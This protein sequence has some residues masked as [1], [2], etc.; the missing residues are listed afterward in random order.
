MI[1]FSIIIP[2]KNEEINIAHCLD[3]INAIKYDHNRFEVLVVDNGSID[4]TVDVANE[5]GAKVF[6]QP[7]LTISGLRNFGARQARGKVL[8]FL[9]ADC[10]VSENWLSAA[11]LYSDQRDVV[12]FGSPAVLPED[13]TWVQRAWFF[14]RCKKSQVEEVDWHES[15]NFFV[16]RESF[17]SVNG[18]DENL[19][20]CED[21]DLSLRLKKLGRLVA[22]D[23]IRA[24]H[25]REPATVRD[26]FNKE[27]WRSSSNRE[28]LV[29]GNFKLRELPSLILPLVH[30]LLAFLLVSL[31]LFEICDGSDINIPYFFLLLVWQLPLLF[32]A[33]WKTRRQFSFVTGLQLY[34]LLN[35][36]FF[37]RGFACMR[38]S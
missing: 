20:T 7:D 15:A 21:Y 16:R 24:M 3:S 27:R 17:E 23:R 18:F 10:T 4:L 22:D 33:F 12:A 19:V 34:A 36:Y 6:V 5:K 31:V 1:D 28:R 9:D 2:A 30:C 38:R 29:N 13:T 32:L 35:V 8:A 25:H 37:A 11:F 14:V 26:F